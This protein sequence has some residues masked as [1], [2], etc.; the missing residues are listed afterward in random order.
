MAFIDEMIAGIGPSFDVPSGMTMQGGQAIPNNN[1]RG[2]VRFGSQAA[3]E[4]AMEGHNQFFEQNWNCVV[5][6]VWTS[7]RSGHS[8]TNTC[9]ETRRLCVQIMDSNNQWQWLFK[10][11]V[12]GWG[13]RMVGNN[14][15]TEVYGLEDVD[16]ST[17]IV[18][19]YPSNNYTWE[20]WPLADSSSPYNILTYYG[21]VNRTLTSQ[22]K[23]LCVAVQCRRALINSNTTDDRDDSRL[24][25]QLGTD[26][27]VHPRN[28][29]RYISDSGA[30]S[31]I[32]GQGYPY[33][34]YDGDFSKWETIT[35]DDWKWVGFVT[36]VGLPGQQTREV[37]PPWGQWTYIPE[38]FLSPYQITYS[39]LLDYPV[40][41]PDVGGPSIPNPTPTPTPAPTPV[42]N[43][44]PASASTSSW[45]SATGSVVYYDVDNEAPA[46]APG[47]GPAPVPPPEISGAAPSRPVLEI[48]TPK[49]YLT[50]ED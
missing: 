36:G 24:V 22:A 32:E 1:G 48:Q 28:G 25:I 46:P 40:L 23:A 42:P 2:G 47:G 37:G 21:A 31:D 43:P 12:P 6:W 13:K 8:S 35:W 41:D 20:Y 7:T 38:W 9:V 14:W 39:H 11:A 18:R 29:L 34:A 10:E 5:P 16:T 44:A 30:Q 4:K 17:G 45:V 27:Q 26:P 19:T 49:V 3:V 50:I 33:Y 15:S